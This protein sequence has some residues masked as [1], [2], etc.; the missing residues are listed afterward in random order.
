MLT[1]I[2]RDVDRHPLSARRMSAK[3]AGGRDRGPHYP[4]SPAML[5]PSAF[6]NAREKAF[7]YRPPQ[8][9]ARLRDDFSWAC[10]S[11]SQGV[12]LRGAIAL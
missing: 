3:N 7:G 11:L 9:M 2:R 12:S 4:S 1:K 6:A 5:S 10:S 8:A